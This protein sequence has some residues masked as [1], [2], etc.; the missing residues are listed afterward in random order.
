MHQTRTP[1]HWQYFLYLEDDIH[2][3]SRWIEVCD[4][5]CAVHSI[6]L[7]RLLMTA[8]AEVDVISRSLCKALDPTA[9]ANSI[10]AYQRILLSAF[11]K[12]IDTKVSM[13]RYG[14][15]FQPWASWGLRPDCPPDWWTGYNKV[16]HF[17]RHNVQ[18][19]NLGNVLKAI[20]GLLVL[21]ILHYIKKNRSHVFPAPSIF[22]P[23]TF[24]VRQSGGLLLI[25]PD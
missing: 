7:A 13:P 9:N 18:K 8:A 5:N 6:E 22:I 17:R 24:A 25:T 19:A 14:M 12:I 3:L 2:R 15:G 21:L 10:N 11:P 23:D 1:F 20:S 16:K 4:E